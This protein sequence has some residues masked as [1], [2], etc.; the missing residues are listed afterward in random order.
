M[1]QLEEACIEKV[2]GRFA[3]ELERIAEQSL[4]KPKDA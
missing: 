3:P 2:R 4:G 1:K